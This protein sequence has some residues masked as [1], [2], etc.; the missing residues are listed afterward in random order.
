MKSFLFKSVVLTLPFLLGF[1]FMET[2]VRQKGTLAAKR[3]FINSEAE[4]V[5]ALVLG[6]SHC[7]DGLNPAILGLPA[8]NLAYGGQTISIDRELLLKYGP[9]M[10]KL[11]WLILDVSPHRFYL[12]II[13]KDWNHRIYRVMYGVRYK[14]EDFNLDNY[15][16]VL[17][18][19]SYFSKLVWQG[20]SPWEEK[21]PISKQGFP[22]K[23]QSDRFS[24]LNFDSAKINSSFSMY[25][26]FTD[27]ALFRKN[28]N[29][30]NGI[31]KWAEG[32]GI[33]V[34]LVNPPVYQ[35][36]SRGIPLA[37]EKA[38]D[39]LIAVFSHRYPF[40]R[41]ENLMKSE[42][43][44]LTDFKNDNHLNLSG[45]EKFSSMVRAIITKKP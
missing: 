39:S 38:T 17:S 21:I 29:W 22:L 8:A 6:S 37:A 33:K 5:E 16:L 4:N 26:S 1:L 30:L 34:L 20:I 41:Y 3:D 7:Q 35:S 24:K 10:K 15:S 13:E 28:T 32:Q 2:L 23:E 9:R 31:L 36:F 14:T 19:F 25:Y 44:K 27:T 42:K 18:N 12:D 11:K 43:F 45:A 40:I